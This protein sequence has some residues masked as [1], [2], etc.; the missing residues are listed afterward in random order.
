MASL[1]VGLDIGGTKTAVL[2]VSEGGDVLARAA[3]PTI[4]ASSAAFLAGVIAL[5]EEAMARVTA[6]PMVRAIGLGIPGQV[7]P[8]NGIVRRAVNLNLDAYPLARRLSAR[9]DCPALMENDVR[10]AAIGAYDHLRRTEPVGDIAYVGIGTGIS[11]GLILNGRL[12]RGAHGMAGEIGHVIV[13]PEGERCKCGA[14]G[15]LE[16]IVS[17]PAIARQGAAFLPSPVHPGA[18][19]EA[20]NRGDPRAEALV[21]RVSAQLARAIQWLI[22]TYDVE[23]VVLGGGVTRAGAAFFNPIMEA[24]AHMRRESPLARAMLPATKVVLLPSDY[25]AGLW[26]AIRLARQAVSPSMLAQEEMKHEQA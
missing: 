19:Y 14:R 8:E 6:A 15:C 21:G 9:F 3:A 2:I 7:E 10:T 1:Y 12:H 13:A 5:I 17:G 18:V 26:G 22:M 4:T 23:K 24:L 16:T 20:A 25:N 11:A